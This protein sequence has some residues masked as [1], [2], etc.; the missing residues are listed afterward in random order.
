MDLFS[1]IFSLVPT[2]WSRIG[3]PYVGRV[4]AM[5]FLWSGLRLYFFPPFS[6]LPFSVGEDC[7]GRGGGSFSSSVLAAETMIS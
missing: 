1:F 2:F 6:M 5:S 4:D 3:D 7:V